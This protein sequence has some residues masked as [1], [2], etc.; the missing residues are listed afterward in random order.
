[1]KTRVLQRGILF[2]HIGAAG[3]ITI[4]IR[5]QKHPSIALLSYPYHPLL[6][7]YYSCLFLC[8]LHCASFPR[9]SPSDRI[10]PLL[11]SSRASYFICTPL[12]FIQIMSFVFELSG[13]TATGFLDP[14][15]NKPPQQ[16]Q[17]YLRVCYCTYKVCAVL[18]IAVRKLHKVYEYVSKTSSSPCYSK[19]F[20]QNLK[21]QLY[22]L[23]F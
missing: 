20:F 3:L 12:T 4:T 6:S 19:K 11:L 23:A 16:R 5:F 1:M 9:S 8:E 15:E 17:A 2:L 21:S 10:T 14:S 18:K 22:V 7:G 13:F